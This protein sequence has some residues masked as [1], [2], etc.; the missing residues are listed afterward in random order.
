MAGYLSSA[1]TLLQVEIDTV[2]SVHLR[3][4]GDLLGHGFGGGLEIRETRFSFY[5]F[6]QIWSLYYL[7]CK[8]FPGVG[9]Q[10]VGIAADGKND[11]CVGGDGSGQIGSSSGG[12]FLEAGRETSRVFVEILPNLALCIFKWN[13]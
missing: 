3:P 7:G 12:Q 2:D 10:G 8:P 6:C 5:K 13:L 9:L 11:D 1:G 4:F